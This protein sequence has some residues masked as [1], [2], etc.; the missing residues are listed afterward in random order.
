VCQ[1]KRRQPSCARL[2]VRSP[3]S[4]C[5]ELGGA[6]CLSGRVGVPATHGCRA[7]LTLRVCVPSPAQLLELLQHWALEA[8]IVAV[9]APAL[10]AS[11]RAAPAVAVPALEQ[12]DALAVFA[13]VI[14]RQQKAD[15]GLAAGPAAADGQTEVRACTPRGIPRPLRDRGGQ[16]DK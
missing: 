5:R 8:D 13:A 15:G 7:V 10:A 16:T 12:R 11:L 6:G 9:A 3:A 4:C 2:N 14:R 1:G